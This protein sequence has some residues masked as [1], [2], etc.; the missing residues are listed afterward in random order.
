MLQYPPPLYLA[1]FLL[2][3]ARSIQ[4]QVWHCEVNC[5][6]SKDVHKQIVQT[7]LR[8]A[9]VII[10][11]TLKLCTG[12]FFFFYLPLA[13]IRMFYCWW[14]K[15]SFKEYFWINFLV[16][17]PPKHSVRKKSGIC[18]SL[19]GSTLSK[20]LCITAQGRQVWA[21]DSVGFKLTKNIIIFYFS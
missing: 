2:Q 3:H 1:I 9:T 17:W 5:V 19:M 13:L 7:S 4:D 21:W 6:H 18:L 20:K 16:A 12:I 11:S 8:Q 10:N 15:C 14:G